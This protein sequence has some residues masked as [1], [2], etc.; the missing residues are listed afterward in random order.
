MQFYSHS[1]YYDR[2]CLMRM[3]LDV[4]ILQVLWASCEFLNSPK[5]NVSN[6][7]EVT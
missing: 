5:I 1:S 7:F 2:T 3:G 6:L 4:R